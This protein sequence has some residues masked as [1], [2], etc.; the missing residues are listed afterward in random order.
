[1]VGALPRMGFVFMPCFHCSDPW[2][3]PV[4]PTGAIDYLEG[5]DN[6]EVRLCG[7]GLNRLETPKCRRCGATVAPARAPMGKQ[8]LRRLCLRCAREKLA[9]KFVKL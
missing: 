3:L 6:R 8:V 2:C 7:T 4:C 1:M 9:Q 5:R